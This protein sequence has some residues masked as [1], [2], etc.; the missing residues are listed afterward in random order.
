MR[1]L[2]EPAQGSRPLRAIIALASLAALCD[3]ASASP[4]SGAIQAGRA[5]PVDG[6]LALASDARRFNTWSGYSSGRF[7]EAVATGDFNGDGAID[8]AFARSDFVAQSMTVQFNLGDGTL[9]PATAYPCSDE[10]TDIKSGDIDGD[11]DLDLVV[12][13]MGSSLQNA[14]IHLYFNDSTGRFTRRTATGGVG[15][16]RVVLADLDADGDLDLAMSSG[17]FQQVMSVLL[18]AG[19]GTFGPETR[20]TVGATPRGIAAADFD[21]DGDVDL[22]VA[23]YSTSTLQT[24][25]QIWSN[26]GAAH[27]TRSREIT[28]IQAAD[29]PSLIAD[30]FNRDGR[31]DLA[32]GTYGDRQVVMLGRAGLAFD[33]TVYVTGYTA[34][35]LTSGDLDGDGD[36]DI[37]LATLGSS[38]TGDMSILRNQGNG[39]FDPMRFSSGFNPHDAAIADFDG[40]G[41]ADI[42]VAE[43]GT[44]TGAIHLQRPQFKFGAPGL[45]RTPLP[46]GSMENL[47]VEH[48]GDLD[49]ALSINDPYGSGGFVEIMGNDGR[50]NFRQ[51]QILPPGIPGAEV[52]HVQ[53]ADL[54][55][56][57][58]DDLVWNVSQF[59]E[60]IAPLVTSL[61][62]G[63]GVFGPTTVFEGTARNGSVSVG[64][65]DNDGDIDLISPQFTPQLAV[66]LN[67]GDATFEPAR[68]V[69]VAEFPG[70]IIVADLNGD[71]VLDLATV[72]NGAY[73]SSKRISVLRGTGNAR[74][75]PFAAYTVG[76]GPIGLVAV[77]LDHDGD[78]D[79]ATS[80]NGGDDISNFADESTT[81]L[82]NDGTGSF[83]TITTYAGEDVGGYL[84][85]WAIRA[86]D[87]DG[88]GNNDIVV[89]NVMGNDAGVYY[90]RGDG[91]LEPEQVRYGLQNGAQ[92]L[93][94]A[95]YNGDARPDIVASGYLQSVDPLFPPTGIVVLKNRG[96]GAQPEDALDE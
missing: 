36:S 22:A 76:Q 47:D 3:V 51:S 78:L 60:P 26:D 16:Q 81:V 54:D 90:G 15:P 45:T 92:T 24:Y 38:S 79:L 2:R 1:T 89:S 19:D 30:D 73:G 13:S 48:D 7:P 37:V 83:R 57:G 63:A 95:D 77:D 87:V 64:D 42:A 14:T 46:V 34:W 70:M 18:N 85:E 43:G 9:G 35:D 96:G 31:P 84:S 29:Q 8:V 4:E 44:E 27:F 74:F 68:I 56:D 33:Q 41:K 66:Y 67:R 55:G 94:V 72:H 23:R 80:N 49:L 21:R 59:N 52:G 25:V 86:G 11:G 39:T 71:G 28:S 10:S 50:A 6:S 62:D 5:V 12:V 32:L 40:D 82:L 58:W 93:T 61:N 17:W 91:T 69:P 88:D 53:P 20:Y 75:A 65:L